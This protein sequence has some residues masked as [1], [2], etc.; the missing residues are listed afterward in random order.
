[1]YAVVKSRGKQLKISPGEK[2]RVDRMNASV[3]DSVVMN[4]VLV[5]AKEGSD[6]HIGT[7]FIEGASVDGKVLRHARSKKVTIMKY[8]PKKRYRIKKGHRQDYTLLEITSVKHGGEVIKGT[9]EPVKQ[10][11]KKTEAKTKAKPKTSQEKP[12]KD[13]KS[14]KS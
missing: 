14:E 7:P 4:E 9:A 6:V 5:I 1:M 2:V 12:K 13:A 11:K 3:G 8:K 10:P